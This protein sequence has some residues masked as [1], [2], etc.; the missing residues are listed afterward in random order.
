MFAALG[1]SLALAAP[2][3]PSVGEDADIEM[4]HRLEGILHTIQAHALD[5]KEQQEKLREKMVILDADDSLREEYQT[6]LEQSYKE[7]APYGGLSAVPMHVPS[8]PSTQ[9][10]F[11]VISRARSG[12]SWMRDMLNQHPDIQCYRELLAERQPKDLSTWYAKFVSGHKQLLEQPMDDAAFWPMRSKKFQGFKWYH[13]QADIE[14]FS[15]FWKAS[16]D[17]TT[18]AQQS[19]R[20]QGFAKFLKE[21]GFKV[22]IVDRQA[23]LTRLVSDHYDGTGLVK[24][25]VDDLP[26]QLELDRQYGL[27]TTAWLAERGIAKDHMLRVTYENLL[28]DAHNVMRMVYNFLGADPNVVNYTGSFYEPNSR[29]EGNLFNLAADSEPQQE[30]RVELKN[31]ISNLNDVAEKLRQEAPSFMDELNNSRPFHF[32]RGRA[33]LPSPS[34]EANSSN[35]TVVQTLRAGPS[36][37]AKQW[38]WKT[39]G[40]QAKAVAEAEEKA[41][42]EARKKALDD[43]KKTVAEAEMVVQSADGARKKAHQ[44]AEVK[45]NEEALAELKL[46]MQEKAKHTAQEKAE[47]VGKAAATAKANADEAADTLS[48][49]KGEAS[50][51]K[52]KVAAA[53][54]AAA[55]AKA[56]SAAAAAEALSAAHA[57]AREWEV[58][59]KSAMAHTATADNGTA[60]TFQSADLPAIVTEAQQKADEAAKEEAKAE[61]QAEAELLAISEAKAKAETEANSMAIAKARAD[62]VVAYTKEMLSEAKDAVTRT[63]FAAEQAAKAEA[64]AVA[65]HEI[66][67]AKVKSSAARVAD[68]QAAIA[69]ASEAGQQ[70][71]QKQQKQQDQTEKRQQQQQQRQTYKEVFDQSRK[72]TAASTAARSIGTVGSRSV[73]LSAFRQ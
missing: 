14:L 54:A 2:L 39:H 3:L 25:N 40:G 21:Y 72:S 35:Q 20:A 19:S 48:K 32:R 9:G 58:Q 15:P 52:L 10:R 59:T 23:R 64:A 53:A 43:A 16:I 22:I 50:T 70:R 67:L 56:K 49:M 27:E 60:Q 55:V 18:R 4:A 71:M 37:Q 42:Q 1:A 12:A 68:E 36:E 13:S 63:K 26:A 46:E 11:I 38:W 66:A 30:H 17:N 62:D 33:T 31:V 45:S 44:L 28:A 51:A 34:E 61:E 29:Y 41:Q 57:K 73:S 65:K 69:S 5:V 24:I 8:N 6:L 47:L 7:A